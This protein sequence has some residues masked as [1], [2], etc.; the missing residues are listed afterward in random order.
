MASILLKN[1]RIFDGVSGDCPEGM[2]LL[3][4]S[5]II[6][7]VSDK[8]IS[9][10]GAHVIDAGGRTLMPGLIDAHIH[11]YFCDVSW[12]KM[13]TAGEASYC[14]CGANAEVRARLRVYDG[15]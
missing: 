5:G 2:Q 12:H 14:A 8:P 10:N 15:P 11:A 3:V 9:T 7:E 1:A 4:E 6:R 13:D